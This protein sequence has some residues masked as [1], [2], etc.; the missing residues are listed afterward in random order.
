MTHIVFVDSNKC[1]LRAFEVALERG[2]R[3]SLIRCR[4]FDRFYAVPRADAAIARMDR[5]REV[6]D[7]SDPDQVTDAL[8]A[9]AAETPVDAVVCVAH[10]AVHASAVAAARLGIRTTSA[11]GIRRARDKAETRRVLAAQGIPSARFFEF[12]PSDI[13]AALGAAESIGYP[14]ILKPATGYGSLLAAKVP[15]PAALRDRLIHHAQALDAA[16]EVIRNEV[17]GNLVLEE[18][19]LGELCSVE[20]GLT[21][22]GHWTVLM[23][24]HRKRAQHDEILEMGSTVPPV[25]DPAEEPGL[26]AY[27]KRV[28][29][30]LG[31]DLGLF[32]VEMMLTADGPRLVEVN[33][34]I[35]GGTLPELFAIVTGA[36]AYEALIDI[37]LGQ[38]PARLTYPIL[39][40]VTSR[41]VCAL[42]DCRAP[43]D[44]APDWQDA[45]RAR[46]FSTTVS[47][48]PGQ[49]CRKMTDN[50]TTLGMIQ[51][52]AESAPDSKA[53]A[54]AI[55][56]EMQAVLGFPLM[57]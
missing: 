24:A 46:L 50:F 36:D 20:L 43:D 11:D 37:H 13:D 7:S 35:M 1:G 54:E 44:L 56:H 23:T 5:V 42:R 53:E 14:L 9:I 55:L 8:R 2:Y 48:A 33:P 21:A 40:S 49:V 4:A 27:A 26:I 16:G 32:H 38:E 29:R 39:R 30:A 18:L 52:V 51:T 6:G 28:V 17:S 47:I 10:W 57:H 3:V 12:A 22:A 41:G 45:F 15:D 25:F 31:L 19:L 34:R